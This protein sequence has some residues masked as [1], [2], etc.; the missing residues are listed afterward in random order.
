MNFRI[1]GQKIKMLSKTKYLGLVLEESLSFKYHLQSF[2]K[3]IGK[4]VQVKRK[5]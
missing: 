4:I 5:L 1:S 3:Y 2:A